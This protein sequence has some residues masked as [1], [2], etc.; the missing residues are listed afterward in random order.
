MTLNELRGVTA[1]GGKNIQALAEYNHNMK[2]LEAYR[3]TGL[4][5]KQ[6]Q[7]IKDLEE[8]EDAP[9]PLL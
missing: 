3:A 5:P 4:T 6:V 9:L 7:A 8:D 1:K 2:E